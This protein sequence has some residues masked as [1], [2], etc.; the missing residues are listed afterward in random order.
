MTIGH[1]MLAAQGYELSADAEP[2]F[3]DYIERRARAADASPTPAASAT[4]SS[5][6]GSATPPASSP[7]GGE[8]DLDALRRLVPDDL[9]ASTVF[10][11]GPARRAV[12]ERRQVG[13]L[14]V[15]LGGRAVELV[16]HDGLVAD[17]PGVVTGLDHVRVPG[18]GVPSL[19]AVVVHDVQ[20]PRDDHAH[21]MGL[22]AVAADHPA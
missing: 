20:G 11:D 17:D 1:R 15:R 19:A 9:L 3:R 22:A 14:S 18:E 12:S 7:R 2:V 5:G 6:P 10:R 21:V 8:I 16:G 13:V 4:P